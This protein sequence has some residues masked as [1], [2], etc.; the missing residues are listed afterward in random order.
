MAKANE[1]V[2]HP[3]VIEYDRARSLITN[4]RNPLAPDEFFEI[5]FPVPQLSDGLEAAEAECKKR[6]D[7]SLQDIIAAG[8]RNASTRP[9][10]I[11]A[12]FEGTV[13]E[14]T[15][16]FTPTS[17]KTDAHQQMQGL[18][19]VYTMGTKARTGESVKAKAAKAEAMENKLK[20]IGVTDFDAFLARAKEMGIVE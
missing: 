1:K 18:A 14:K 17:Q 5:V 4:I 15:K 2:Y 8:I 7:C 13:D 9:D 11:Q 19:D 12:G 6:Y 3:A 10:Y 20:A 16:K